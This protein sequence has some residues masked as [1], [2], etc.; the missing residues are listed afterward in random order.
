MKR[1]CGIDPRGPGESPMTI[2]GEAITVEGVRPSASIW[3]RCPGLFMATWHDLL[4]DVWL[5][6]PTVELLDQLVDRQLALAERL[7]GG[8]AVM[9]VIQ[10]GM[11]RLPDEVRARAGEVAKQTSE[12][13]RA[14]AHVIEGKGFVP[15]MIRTA[16]TTINFM[17]HPPYP[18]TVAGNVEE[19][20]EW[21]APHVNTP[22]G[23]ARGCAVG[24]QRCARSGRLGA[25][26]TAVRSPG[27][28]GG[29]TRRCGGPRRSS[30][31][32]TR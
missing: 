30:R 2:S 11:A 25:G 4:V 12:H 18:H 13:V 14:L 5:D 10:I 31:D 3:F 1:S 17:S 8:F 7:P 32:R 9:G 22:E 21:I 15:A 20:A 23:R 19:A 6:V 29:H 24:G 27:C 28:P 16:A 26:L